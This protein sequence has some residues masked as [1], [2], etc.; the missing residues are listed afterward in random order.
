MIS[1]A[2]LAWFQ[3]RRQK[4]RFA[5]ALAGVAFAV[6]LMLMQLGFH[7]A[8]FTSAVIVHRRLAADVVLIHPN[9]TILPFPALFARRRLYQALGF[10]GVESVTP[11]YTGIARWKNPITGRSRNIF[12][13][14]VDPSE[15]VL[16]VPEVRAARAVMRYPDVVLYD[17]LSR[18]EFGPVA[19]TLRAGDEIG[20]EV[21]GRRVTVKS[22]FRLGCSFGIDG[23]VVASDLNFHRIFPF[24]SPGAISL[25]LVKLR[26]GADA[27]RVRAA[28]S[29]ALPHDV[30]ALTREE[31]IAREVRYWETNTPIGYV[32][33]FGVLMG[34]VVGAIIVYQ[35]LFTDITD[36]LSEY[37]TLKALGYTQRYL[38]S[39]VLMEALIL[40]VVGYL[41][42]IGVCV[43]LYGLTAS[44]TRLPMR[45]A[46]GRALLA[47]CLT[48]V[49]CWV[50]GLIAMRKLRAADP[51]EIF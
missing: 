18:P 51:A 2:R 45:L 15:D 24:Q 25:G 14:G 4:V 37:A 19:A 30:D 49:M 41:P 40:A 29:A 44:A 5:V 36:H 6:A 43:W 12:V 47:L 27:T 9:Y 23:T 20:T 7:D 42:A 34:L 28:L 22:L 35:I 38:A 13:L 48:I 32:F 17:E 1:A 3:L 33:T 11:L 26:P 46:P 16:D 10:D 8:L 31:F 50:S 39:V 21:D